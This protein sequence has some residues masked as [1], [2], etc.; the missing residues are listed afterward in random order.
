VATPLLLV[1]AVAVAEPLNV[2]PA[3][4]AVNV[5]V[6]PLSRLLPASFTV[7]CNAV[8]KAVLIVALC[9]VPVVVL[10]LAGEPALFVRE[11]M[12][13]AVTPETMAVTV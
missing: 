4:G 11:K 13:P 9:G 5:T 3:P 7:A 6:I 2:A 8:E 12:A 1:T 10:T